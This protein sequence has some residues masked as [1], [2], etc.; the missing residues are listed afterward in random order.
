MISLQNGSPYTQNF[1][2][3]AASGT[4]SLLPLGW[5]F[6]ETGTNANA[7]YT[8][9]TGSGNA[10]DTYSFG[11][12]GSTERALGG[13]QSGSLVPRIGA[14]LSNDTGATIQSIVL[15][16][17][18]EQWRLGTAGRADRLDFEYSLDAS[19]L[20]TGTWT[21]VDALDFGAP[22]SAGALGALNGNDAA[23][24]GAVAGSIGGLSLAP[25]ATL[26]IRW[27]DF[28][29]SGADDGLAIDDLS[30]TTTTSGGGGTPVVNL[31]VSSAT[32]YEAQATVLTLT[33]TA[34]SV[35]A[36][37]QT[38]TLAVSGAGI[39]AGDYLLSSPTIT[40]PAGQA[41]ASV[42]FVVRDDAQAEGSE[43]ATVAIVATS[44]GLVAGATASRD[45]T[46]V[47]NSASFLTLVGRATSAHGAEIPA[48]DA[49]TGR[50]FVAAGSVVEVYALA[51]SGA[52]SLLGALPAGFAPAA[53][54]AAQPTSVAVHA[55]LVAVA[56]DITDTA[57]GAHRP[58]VVG[59]YD[60]GDGSLLAQVS[61][62]HL[63][64]MLSFSPDGRYLL[65]ANEGEPN[66]Y[67]QP[68][69]FDP[70]G[71]VSIIDLAAGAGAPV[72]HTADFSA[73][74]SQ[75]AAL[76]AAGV[77]IFGPNATVA[78][79]LEPESISITPDGATAIVTLQENNA[80]AVIDIAS[81]TVTGVLPLGTKDFS[82]AGQGLDP[83]DRDNAAA[84]ANWPVQGLLQP[85]TVVNFSVGGQLYF[86]T[87]NEGDARDYTGFGEEVR[88]GAAGYNLDDTAFPNEAVLKGN[89]ALGRLQVTKASGDSDG[90]GD[91]DQ[92]HAFGGRSFTIWD[93]SGQRVFD[94]GDQLERITATRV[95]TLFNS[96]GVAGGFDSRSDNKGPE[97]EGLAVGSI[98]GRTYAFVGL[99][100]TG[101]VIVYDVSN[102]AAPSF[103]QYL[104]LPEDVAPEGLSFV[105]AADSPSGKPLLVVASE[106]SKTVTVFEV[107]V[108]LRIADIQGAGHLSPLL[109]S[110]SAT[111]AVQQVPGIVT[112]I[113]STGFYL[114]DPQ[115]DGNDATSEAIF[116]YTGSG[117][118]VLAARSV[119]EAVLVSGTVSEFRPGG[120]ASGNLTVTQIS[121][122]AGV[123]SLAVAA[124]TDAPAGG[125][126]PVVLG[127]DRVLPT[128]AIND[129]F[130]PG[131]PGNP[132]TGGDFDPVN[133][134]M[135]FWESLEG[136]L[137]QVNNPV[138]SAPTASFG[139]SQELWVLANGGV[140][141]STTARGGALIS[142]GDF[143]P[144]R[145][146]LDDLVNSTVLPTVDVGARL[147]TATGVV[148][149]EF[150][151]YQV[152]VS[153]APSVVAASPLQREVTT[154]AP[155][156]DA[157]RV[158]NFNVENLDP[159]DGAAM[160]AALAQAIAG[161]LRSPDILTLEEV[162]DN[163]GPTNN[164]V[165]DASQ[166]LQLLVDAIV[167][168]GGPRY[169]WQQI[170]PVNGQDGGEPGGNIRV[171]FLYNPARVDF[172]A[173]SLQRLV[174]TDPSDGDAFAASRKP[175][176][177]S[178]V[179]HGE[180]VTVIGNHF[181]SKGGDQPLYGVTQPPLLVSETQ[182]NAQ[183]EI[184]AGYVE[185]LL[186]A[187]PQANVLVTGDL[188]D[189]EFS[190]PLLRLKAGG[191]DALIET[192]PA[193]E[194]YTYNYEGNAQ[195]LDHILASD[196]LSSR[197]A[198]FD[199][200][201]INSE[202][203]SQISDHDPSVASFLI[204]LGLTLTGTAGRDTLNGGAANDT[205]T[206]GAGRDSLRGGAGA[207]RFVY[208]SVLDAGDVIADFEL[209]IDR[210]AIGQ[211]LASVG[212]AGGNAVADGYL[213]VSAGSG[214][215][216]VSFDADGSAGAGAARVLVELVG[217][218]A[219]DI[220]NPALLLD[221]LVA[222][223]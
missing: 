116:V 170:D 91:F 113:G 156:A 48:F 110:A 216:I 24:R 120:A 20:S 31:S 209:G 16:Y 39:S 215:A 49:A 67:N 30:I 6:A 7:L 45:I 153:S 157:L 77:R 212:Y 34:S 154:L 36:S 168:A 46:L 66:S 118:A 220:T 100:R 76:R 35:L 8:A 93:S 211:L 183:A 12:A 63:P 144:E 202:F 159:G 178:F 127:T 13:L 136:M 150:G 111:A 158:A 198:G 164:G 135:D 179:F 59:L 161:N 145:I 206:G 124:W 17:T 62:G 19:S 47:D 1:D 60:S 147:S 78:Q 174:D 11:A 180:T 128:T 108:P 61:V 114:Q 130:T 101:D 193:N 82:L 42:S 26:W 222:G 119:G 56:W 89:S 199:V 74:N 75:L 83:S 97:P 58:G 186:A 29:A 107:A 143:N 109:A 79:D 4:A 69:S 126:A 205:L 152:M 71:S 33:A 22:V 95:P 102:P 192:L 142:A 141:A 50:L 44:A 70:E 162:Q 112:A 86:I 2:G 133:E 189:F 43:T 40:I 131:S 73:F 176:V 140:G 185:S 21:A 187:N 132:E 182:R 134:G 81:A 173:G 223:A 151:N 181:N 54:S 208:T 221:S 197:L 137:V 18:G 37:A 121:H 85:D 96:D 163:N 68:D 201:H 53:G 123:Q 155:A 80:V 196:R 172:V 115:P 171:A 149:Y 3:L 5:F 92:I 200:V 160:F 166:T 106:V 117:S 190:S 15:A 184:V 129:D 64:D 207:D 27:S 94:S 105:P 10:G 51:A 204:P 165:V 55:G 87:A 14:Q 103:V 194:R 28:N 213:G 72:V 41:S 52:P 148:D 218:A 188:N 214:R 138:A 169:A 146:Q 203:A 98:G 38:V 122:N 104:E 32:A 167:A 191:L 99:E 177:G 125:I 217:V 175:L 57:S 219:A 88:V 139:T 195:T 210:L 90:D 9:G 65:V 25:G 23:N 84:I